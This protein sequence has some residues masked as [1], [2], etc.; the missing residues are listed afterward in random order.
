MLAEKQSSKL[1]VTESH[2]EKVCSTRMQITE[3]GIK[4][5]PISENESEGCA[6]DVKDQGQQDRPKVLKIYARRNKKDQKVVKPSMQHHS[7][8]CTRTI[9]ACVTKQIGS[10]DTNQEGPNTRNK[11]GP[12]KVD[13]NSSDR[14]NQRP[15]RLIKRP[16]RFN[17]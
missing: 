5:Q 12:I 3:D 11:N 9:E 2:V 15:K 7:N 14:P 17:T 13:T 8:E 6:S 16:S 10:H 1:E 4:D